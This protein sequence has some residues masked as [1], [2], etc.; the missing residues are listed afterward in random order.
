MCVEEK[1]IPKILKELLENKEQRERGEGEKEKRRYC[2]IV[3]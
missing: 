1:L 3:R 2:K